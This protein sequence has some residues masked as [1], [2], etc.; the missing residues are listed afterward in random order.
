MPAIAFVTKLA[1]IS[2][3]YEWTII[4]VYIQ[5][6]QGIYYG[7]PEI[8]SFLLQGG[9]GGHNMIYIL[10]IP[11]HLSILWLENTVRYKYMNNKPGTGGWVCE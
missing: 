1:G 7:H 6:Y 11:P 3:R 9:V 8:I 5:G 10:A 4:Y 2:Q